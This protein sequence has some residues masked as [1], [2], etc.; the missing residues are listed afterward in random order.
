MSFLVTYNFIARRGLDR[1]YRFLEMCREQCTVAEIGKE[2]SISPSLAARLRK[3]FFVVEYRLRPST[4][5]AIE[6]HLEATSDICHDERERFNR[7][8]RT[9]GENPP[10]P[11]LLV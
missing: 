2:F 8:Q 11:R 6:F 10:G 3:R 7:L 5:E 9:H 1:S 4:I